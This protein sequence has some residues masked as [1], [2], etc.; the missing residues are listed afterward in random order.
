MQNSISL[1]S[2]CVLIF[3]CVG[4]GLW[5]TSGRWYSSMVSGQVVAKA[6]VHCGEGI[7]ASAET[8]IVLLCHMDAMNN[9][10]VVTCE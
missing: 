5:V 7:G 9:A 4:C 3:E 8:C 1:A 2:K 6:S 10:V